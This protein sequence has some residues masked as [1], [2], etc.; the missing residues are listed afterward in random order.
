MTEAMGQANAYVAH[1]SSADEHEQVCETGSA[2]PERRET[3]RF[4][5]LIR[6]AK[7][8]VGDAEYLCIIKDAS[9]T[10]VSLRIFHDLP[11]AQDVELV[12]GNGD[13][14]AL[15]FVREEAGLAAYTFRD[16]VDL[17]R[18]IEEPQ[19]FRKRG[20]R[21]NLTLPATVTG[22]SGSEMVMVTNISQQGARI[23]CERQ[24]AVHER[25]VLSAKGLPEVAARVRWRKGHQAGV[26]FEQGFPFEQFA[27]L[28]ADLQNTP[29][30]N[31]RA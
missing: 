7:V 8:R 16:A 5:L 2:M 18:L 22:S 6:S 12:L 9:D 21:L 31:G 10:G 30:R 24:F 19:A 25:L 11:Q 14:Y 20:S 26:A 15:Q 3:P 23:E 28:A 27:R 1:E 29:K 4:T 17:G 13:T